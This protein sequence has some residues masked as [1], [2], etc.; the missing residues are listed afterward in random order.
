MVH[1][2]RFVR[3]NYL[4]N[5]ITNYDACKTVCNWAKSSTDCLLKTLI[6]PRMGLRR[7]AKCQNRELAVTSPDC[8]KVRQNL[9]NFSLGKQ[10][11]CYSGFH[12]SILKILSQV[13]FS[14]RN[15]LVYITNTIGLRTRHLSDKQPNLTIKETF[16]FVLFR[17]F[18]FIFFFYNT[19][20]NY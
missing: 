19:I 17:I 6:I 4:V 3:L 18:L 2:T 5:L 1:K 16:S 9:R 14:D 13:E 7:F 11:G 8:L 20:V 12:N 15:F 10:T